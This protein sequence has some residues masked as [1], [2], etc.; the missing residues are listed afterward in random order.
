MKPLVHVQ[1]LEK[2]AYTYDVS[3]FGNLTAGDGVT[4]ESLE[5]C[6]FDAAASLDQYFAN[7]ELQLDGRP[8]GP[9]ATRTMR[10][11]PACV[12]QRMRRHTQR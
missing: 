10:R 6:L 3:A 8:I 4:F 11:D 1:R 7:V 5:L 2:N 12:A 9:C